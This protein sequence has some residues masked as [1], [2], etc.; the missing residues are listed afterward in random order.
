MFIILLTLTVITSGEVIEYKININPSNYFDSIYST[1]SK[2]SANEKIF[3]YDENNICFVQVTNRNIIAY[4]QNWQTFER[5]SD[6]LFEISRH[7]NQI[8][9]INCFKFNR[10]S[11]I[12]YKYKDNNEIV[13]IKGKNNGKTLE[14]SFDDIKYDYLSKKLY[15]I[16]N[17]M[18][19]D[20]EMNDFENIWKSTNKASD[21]YL[22]INLI[23]TIDKTISD[24]LI[25]ED[26][27]YIIKDNKIFKK[28]I[29]EKDY[30]FVTT[31]NSL[32]FN[33]IFYKPNSDYNLGNSTNVYL[34]ILYG[35]ELLII[36]IGLFVLNY[37]GIIKKRRKNDHFPVLLEVLDEKHKNLHK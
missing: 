21:G 18:I 9:I 30:N 19:Y 27:I 16:N 1:I 17:S 12:I 8:K 20:I 23:T 15:L 24:F 36:F 2:N 32:H 35:M 28:K 31:T 7:P 33:Y 4:T 10:Y 5:T 34:L 26:A 22:K 14:I 29:E 13:M 6:S 37:S 25:I 3:G 11:Y